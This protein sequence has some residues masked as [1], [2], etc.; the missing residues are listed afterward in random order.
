[1]PA[2]EKN[3]ILEK[4][5]RIEIRLREIE[6]LLKEKWFLVAADLI[7]VLAIRTRRRPILSDKVP[8]MSPPTASGSNT[9]NNT[10]PASAFE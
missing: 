8:P 2:P 7:A 4:S 6:K 5:A 3:I 1:M 9:L 10:V